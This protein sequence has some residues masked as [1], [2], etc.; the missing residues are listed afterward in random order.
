MQTIHLPR[1]E[2]TQL[3]K[4]IASWLKPGGLLLANFAVDISKAT[5]MEKWLD[6]EKGWMYWSS[7][8]EAG[9]VKM[10]EEAGLEILFRETKQITG[11]ANFVWLL[12]RQKN[13]PRVA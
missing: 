5:V 11:D 13:V 10:L 2:Q 3:V 12:A 6:E 9:S 7:L 4:K 8:G 1:E